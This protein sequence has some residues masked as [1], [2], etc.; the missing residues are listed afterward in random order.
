M[1]LT[2]LLSPLEESLLIIAA[3]GDEGVFLKEAHG[4]GEADF[5]VFVRHM[6]L[7]FVLLNPPRVCVCLAAAALSD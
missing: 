6:G 5:G 2:H 7:C 3:P 1:S 4:D